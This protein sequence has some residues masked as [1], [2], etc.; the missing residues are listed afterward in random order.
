M[1]VY[2]T[3]RIGAIA[4]SAIAENLELVPDPSLGHIMEACISIHENDAKMFD[5]LIELDFVSATNEGALLEAEGLAAKGEKI[6]DKIK[7]LFEMVINFIKKAVANFIAKII[8]LVK[9]DKK[10]YETYKD[11]LK[12]ENLKGFPGII[13]FAFP[14]A[15][16]SKDS[17]DSTEKAK[18]FTKEF[19]T[20]VQRED[21]REAIDNAWE[22]FKKKFDTEKEAYNKKIEEVAFRKKEE[23]W[24]PTESW[25]LT[26][27]ANS[28]N[29]ASQ[30][31]KDM[32]ADAAKTIAALKELQADAKKNKSNV[33]KADNGE[34]EV[35][36]MKVLYD[37]A[38]KTT[39]FY[40]KKFSTYTN[41]ASKQI[42]AYRKAFILCGRYALKISKGE[43]AKAE[44]AKNEAAITY[45]LGESSN[46]YVYECLGY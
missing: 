26:A 25:Q 16:F 38:S 5:S 37:A 15:A 43:G 40:S 44:E 32:K 11:T 6:L 7:H 3:N 20:K 13:D 9:S 22:E 19:N 33:N 10:L 31:I 18:S 21:T 24:R 29:N 41:I 45:A 30:T 12:L 23:K 39:K 17:L 34:V 28:V 4:E 1:G 8:D 42:A 27:M 36:K 2:S 46:E 35:Y 14:N